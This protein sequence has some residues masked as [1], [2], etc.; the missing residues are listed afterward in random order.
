M[1]GG[2]ARRGTSGERASTPAQV[3]SVAAALSVQEAAVGIQVPR[4]CH[5]AAEKNTEGC[6][7]YGDDSDQLS[8]RGYFCR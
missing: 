7:R 6:E 4:F 2:S 5:A 3:R 1:Y 8:G